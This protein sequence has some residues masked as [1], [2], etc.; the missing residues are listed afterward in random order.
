LLPRY[1]LQLVP[2]TCF[3]DD[4]RVFRLG[5]GYLPF[6]RFGSALAA[7]SLVMDAATARRAVNV[8]DDVI[9]ARH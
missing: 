6:E 2:G 3:G 8:G 9:V 5:F 4:S 7:L 1:D